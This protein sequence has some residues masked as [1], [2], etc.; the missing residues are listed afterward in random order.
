M[1]HILEEKLHLSFEPESDGES[2]LRRSEA[3]IIC[4]RSVSDLIQ[5]I[6]KSVSVTSGFCL[7]IYFSLH[8]M[9]HIDVT[10]S[11]LTFCLLPWCHSIAFSTLM[12]FSILKFIFNFD[13]TFSTSM[14]QCCVFYFHAAFSN[15]MTFSS[16]MLHFLPWCH[17]FALFT[18]IRRYS[19]LMTFPTVNLN[20]TIRLKCS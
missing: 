11:L 20:W 7:F 13:V 9:I 14:S 3:L 12:A 1:K 4:A 6:F 17:N 10:F 19:T 15:L 8:W 18:L 16:S 5:A 2:S